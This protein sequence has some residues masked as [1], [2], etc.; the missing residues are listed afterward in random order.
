M[1]ELV[2]IVSVDD[3]VVE[4]PAVWTDRLA[5]RYHDTCPGVVRA[6]MGEITLLRAS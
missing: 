3:R 6:P 5:S 1:I 2:L 4:P